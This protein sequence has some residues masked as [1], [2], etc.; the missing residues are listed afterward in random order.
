M[1]N[2]T[3]RSLTTGD[4][5]IVVGLWLFFQLLWFFMLGVHFELEAEKYIDQATHLLNNHRLS[6]VRYLFYFSTTAVIAIN[7]LLGWGLYGALI[8]IMAVNLISYLYFFKA[9]YFLFQNRFFAWGVV[10][11]LLSF[12]PYQSW[13]LYLYTECFFYS[14]VLLLLSRLILF[15]Q[16]DF[17]FLATTALLL[18][19]VVISRPLGVLLVFP[20]LLFI[21]FKLSK[22]QKLIFGVAALA[23]LLLFNYVVQIVFTTT[24]DWNLEKTM[25]EGDIICNI[26][27]P[28]A[29]QKLHLAQHPNQLYQLAYYVMHNTGHFVQLAFTRLRYFFTMVRDYYSPFHN[30]Y[31]V[32]YLATIYVS[33]LAGAKK[34]L[35][36][37][38]ASLSVFML[39][40][41]ILF[42]LTIALQCDD[43]HNRFILTLMPFFFTM[44]A[45][46]V[47]PF[48][49]R[50]PLFEKWI[51]K[52]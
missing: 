9:L 7:Q 29:G 40:T 45:I 18:L 48:L 47:F 21:F 4:Y 2:R 13:S 46:V 37:L 19:L 28:T 8:T 10:F 51:K 36:V 31:L 44:T 12:W 5:A 1:E 26:P 34:I 6:E 35:R 43:Y 3:V 11:L 33:L 38:P 24:S 30:V 23:G 49:R 39:S 15:R 32:V 27:G 41:I 50:I 16:V 14:A 52:G 22:K 42:S 17:R 25:T 20:A